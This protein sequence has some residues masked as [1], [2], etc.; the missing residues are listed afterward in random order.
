MST[1]V[2]AKDIDGS[3]VGRIAVAAD[4]YG[5]APPEVVEDQYGSTWVL[6]RA[7]AGYYQ[8]VRKA[9]GTLLVDR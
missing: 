9:D 7:G 2:P 8:R 5:D 4:E 3:N 1:K 6:V